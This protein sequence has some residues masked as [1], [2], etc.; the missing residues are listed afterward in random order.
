M[1]VLDEYVLMYE[2]VLYCTVCG[3]M[4]GMGNGEVQDRLE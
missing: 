2:Y 1:F 3:R 4:E